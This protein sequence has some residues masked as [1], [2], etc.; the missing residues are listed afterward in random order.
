MKNKQMILI[1][2]IVI[3]AVSFGVA[4]AAGQTYQTKEAVQQSSDAEADQALGVLP[5]NDKKVKSAAKEATEK[6]KASS[7]TDEAIQEANKAFA[8]DEKKRLERNITEDQL[9]GQ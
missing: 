3:A 8:E 7:E 4:R 2:L 6:L 1:F 5:E 9:A